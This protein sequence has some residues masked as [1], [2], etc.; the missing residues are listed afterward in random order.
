MG[1]RAGGRARWVFGRAGESSGKA[2]RRLELAPLGS[3][4]SLAWGVGEGRWW[5]V[6]GKGVTGVEEGRGEGG[7]GGV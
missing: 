4:S 3:S 5:E 7:S 2:S 6:V 1:G